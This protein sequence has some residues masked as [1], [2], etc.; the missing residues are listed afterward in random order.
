MACRLADRVCIVRGGSIVA[1]GPPRDIFYDRETLEHAGLAP[2]EVVTLYLDYCA[3]LGLAPTERPLVNA[4]L[5]D[6]LVR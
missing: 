3:R 2:P 1:D 4:E 5:L 6:A